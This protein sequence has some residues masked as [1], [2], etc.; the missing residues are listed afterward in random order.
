MNIT[1]YAEADAIIFSR[2]F[3][4]CRASPEAWKLK[5]RKK[6]KRYHGK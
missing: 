4:V 6:K 5:Q 3:Y 1:Q 2:H